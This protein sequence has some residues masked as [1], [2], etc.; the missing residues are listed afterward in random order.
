ME[1]K[2]D[3]KAM[4][5]KERVSY[6]WDYYKLHILSGVVVLIIAAAVIIQIATYK[7]SA[8]NIIMV[9]AY[10]PYS[11]EPEGI[12]EFFM[13]EGLDEAKQK[14]F[15]EFLF[16]S[17]KMGLAM[18]LTVGETDV[19]VAPQKIY[20]EYALSGCMANLANYFSEE[21]LEQYDD[22]L[23]YTTDSDTNETYPCGIL[24]INNPWIKA[25]G[26]GNVTCV[27]G[28]AHNSETAVSADFLRF[29]LNYQ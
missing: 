19:F 22:L 18:K 15:V 12:S 5:G 16:S 10:N 2:P 7:E 6:I 25:N 11:E 8:L 24:L 17:D 28:I 9:D 3:L 1:A 27:F 29:V 21:E 26:Y 14:I 4:S 13:Q 20:N 23:V